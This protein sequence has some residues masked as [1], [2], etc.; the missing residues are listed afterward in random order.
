MHYSCFSWLERRAEIH[1]QSIFFRFINFFN[2]NIRLITFQ[3]IIKTRI[4][5]H[6]LKFWKFAAHNIRFILFFLHWLILN[7][8]IFLFFQVFIRRIKIFIFSAQERSVCWSFI[9]YFRNVYF[10]LIIIFLILKRS[11][12]L[13]SWYFWYLNWTNLI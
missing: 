11:D 5:H 10:F 3:F 12:I 1:N 4:I 8:A 7:E 2:D 6:L 13:F 9:L